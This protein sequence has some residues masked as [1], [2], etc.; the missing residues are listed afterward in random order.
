MKGKGDGKKPK[1]Q[2]NELYFLKRR[3]CGYKNNNENPGRGKFL[4]EAVNTA[5]L[6]AIKIL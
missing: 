4:G 6:W 2:Q 3:L 5:E 1:E